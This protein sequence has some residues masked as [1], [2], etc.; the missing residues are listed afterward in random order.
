MLYQHFSGVLGTGFPLQLCRFQ[1]HSLYSTE[2]QY[3]REV[4]IYV[5]AAQAARW[6][7]ICL[8]MQEA[9]E[10]WVQFP[11]L[12]DPRRREWQPTPG[13]LPGESHGQRRLV[14]RSTWGRKELDIPE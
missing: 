2:S 6:H 13:F 5:R 14:G 11:G 7:R 1:L 10:A 4:A 12:E 9:Q 3:F 8:P